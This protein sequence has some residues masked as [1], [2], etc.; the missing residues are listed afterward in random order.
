M[1]RYMCV[2][3]GISLHHKQTSCFSQKSRLQMW[4]CFIQQLNKNII[5]RYRLAICLC[6]FTNENSSRQSRRASRS[7]F[8]P[9]LEWVHVLFTSKHYIIL[10]SHSFTGRVARILRLLEIRCTSHHE[11]L[12]RTVW[13]QYISGASSSSQV[14]C[15]N[16]T[17]FWKVSCSLVG[18]AK[19]KR[20]MKFLLPEW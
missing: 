2:E 16:P 7:K 17:H 8:D 18:L 1:F 15:Q 13:W 11:V 9:D 6:Y 4:Y 19:K 12:W 5:V 20:R 14:R 10:V 3:A